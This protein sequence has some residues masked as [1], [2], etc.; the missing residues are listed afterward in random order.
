[1]VTVL[2]VFFGRLS[3]KRN[4]KNAMQIRFT[5]YKR[6]YIISGAVVLVLGSLYIV[7]VIVKNRREATDKINQANQVTNYTDRYANVS[8]TDKF[9]RNETVLLISSLSNASMDYQSDSVYKNVNKD[10][11]DKVS[12]EVN[13]YDSPI[14]VDFKKII[15]NSDGRSGRTYVV[16]SGSSGKKSGLLEFVYSQNVKNEWNFVDFVGSSTLQKSSESPNTP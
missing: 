15:V 6:V 10:L 3:A 5:N 16:I 9:L 13:K 7:S 4:Y 14:K 11:L 1:L 12:T 8:E 2:F